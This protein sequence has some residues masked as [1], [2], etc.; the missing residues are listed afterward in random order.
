MGARRPVKR[1]GRRGVLPQSRGG[2]AGKVLKLYCYLGHIVLFVHKLF[3]PPLIIIIILPLSQRVL[4]RCGAGHAPK[5]VHN[6][7][8]LQNHPGPRLLI[9]QV[10]KK[11]REPGR[12][13]GTL[14]NFK[15][16]PTER[17]RTMK[18]SAKDLAN[19]N[20]DLSEEGAGLGMPAPAQAPP[21][22]GQ[23][24]MPPPAAGA[25]I[26]PQQQAMMMQQQVHHTQGSKGIWSLAAEHVER[27]AR[28]PPPPT[29]RA[30]ATTTL[31]DNAGA[32]CRCTC[33]SK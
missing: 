12:G 14:S 11:S 23:P 6:K 22:M 2:Q 16:V 18:L 21:P 4:R 20:F 15:K 13:G 31:Q 30:T 26:D 17:A 27:V 28:T 7:G 25:A 10:L 1:A 32:L 3:S 29:V 9:G 24:A 8:R 19:P 5:S 33:S